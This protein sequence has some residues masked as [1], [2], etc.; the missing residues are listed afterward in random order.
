M[1]GVNIVLKYL[2]ISQTGFLDTF[3]SK[4]KQLQETL[5]FGKIF[6][7]VYPGYI[8]DWVRVDFA[9]VTVT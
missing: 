3:R 9:P 2:Y 7:T 1:M 5:T 6:M 8:L 4:G